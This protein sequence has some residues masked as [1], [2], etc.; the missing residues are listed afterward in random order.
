MPNIYKHNIE[1][2]DVARQVQLFLLLIIHSKGNMYL[3]GGS[4]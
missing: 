2:L 1:E 3:D 4:A